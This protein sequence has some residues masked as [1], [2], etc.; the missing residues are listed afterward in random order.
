MDA[1]AVQETYFW[2]E[3]DQIRAVVDQRRARRWPDARGRPLRIWSAPCATRRGAADAGDAA[4][5]SAAGSIA[6]RSRSSAATPARRRS[7]RRALG[8]V[9]R[10]GRSATCRR[11]CE[12]ST[13][14]RTDDHWIV[15]PELQRR[16]TYDVVNLVAEDQVAR[17]ASAPIIFCRTCSSTSPIAA[18][19]GRWRSSSGDARS[20]RVLCVGASE[21]LLRLGTR[22]RPAG[23]R[24][25]VRVREGS[26]RVPERVACS[27]VRE[28]RGSD[29]DRRRPRAGRR[30]LGVHPQGRQG[31][32]VA[33][34][35]PG[36]GRHGPRRRGGA[37]AGR[38]AQARRRDVRFDHARV[39]TA[40]ISSGGRWRSGRCRSSIVSI[41]ARVERAGAE[42]ASMPA[43]WT[44]C[45]SRPRS[46]PR[47]CSTSP[48][49]SSRRSGRGRR[50]RCARLRRAAPTPPR[51]AICDRSR[52]G[53]VCS[54]SASR[55]AGR[56]TEVGDSA[57]F[58]A[59]FPVPVAIVLHMP[60]G[61]TEA[62][63]KRLDDASALT[64]IE[65]RDGEECVPA[66]C[67]CR[68]PA[69]T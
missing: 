35:V 28:A 67:S 2:R 6:R 60:I 61:Y 10:S 34:P 38:T 12:T 54:S 33:Q 57:G 29:M 56:R 65:A 58:P 17:H 11:A 8:R 39:P 62:Y 63:A 55:P 4:R 24:R 3:I 5:R 68:R 18:S 26:G 20:P 41:A 32:A 50:R 51:P 15:V 22:V 7:P 47:R 52:T 45:R 25:R 66:S 43:P 16:V 44:S 40:S 49:S 14:S 46:R 42:R 23:N 69:A 48:T 30:R 19:G 9:R 37:E 36:G 1:L 53:I 21:S 31:D 59:D 64:V 27:P 13:S